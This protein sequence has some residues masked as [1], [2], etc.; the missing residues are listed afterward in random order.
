METTMTMMSNGTAK[1]DIMINDVENEDMSRSI[2]CPLLETPFTAGC[3]STDEELG[4]V[5]LESAAAEPSEKTKNLKHKK[6]KEIP[7]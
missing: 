1:M 4:E 3:L 6:K 2:N 7:I 5:G